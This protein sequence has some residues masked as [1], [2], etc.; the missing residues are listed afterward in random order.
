MI[1]KMEFGDPIGPTELDGLDCPNT[2]FATCR[3]LWPIK[4]NSQASSECLMNLND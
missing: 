3:C 4:S 1:E 2:C